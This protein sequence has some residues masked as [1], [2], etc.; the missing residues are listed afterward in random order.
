M[1]REWSLTVFVVAYLAAGGFLASSRAC[2][3]P[4]YRFA[5][6]SRE[7]LPWEY[8]VF[9]LH[10][11]T[12]V[13]DEQTTA[14]NQR[15][16]E[17]M[18]TEPVRTNLYFREI[19]VADAE[20]AKKLPPDALRVWEESPDKSGGL[21]V[22]LAPPCRH[23]PRWA[24]LLAGRLDEAAVAGLIGS[25]AR[26]AMAASLAKGGI[27]MILLE[28]ASPEANDAAADAI[29]QTSADVAASKVRR[30]GG[31]GDLVPP[32]EE[33]QKARPNGGKPVEEDVVSVPV[34]LIR[35]RRDDEREK[36]FVEMLML[37]EDDL[38]SLAE[39]PM[40]FAGYGRGR[41]GEPF[42]GQGI[43]PKNLA[44]ELIFLTGACSCEVK[45]QNPGMDLLTTAD[46]DAAAAAMT[47]R[48]GDEEGSEQSLN[49]GDLVPSLSSSPPPVSAKNDVES[50]PRDAASEPLD[51]DGPTH[52][53]LA[54]P[55]DAASLAAPN[56][57]PNDRWLPAEG[58]VH[59]AESAVAE[60]E[61][62]EF[63]RSMAW[64]IGASAAV[65]V[66]LLVALSAL[67]L[68]SAGR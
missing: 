12:S 15:L 44:S 14:I 55:R 8:R 66:V 36:F 45:D 24:T 23:R 61:R 17:L 60:A 26:R 53:A 50:P 7:W 65:V 48:F 67:Y 42:V 49:I 68:R 19:N 6:Y 46:W 43:S 62:G 10:D 64:T 35:V 30:R 54:P 51:S 40:V 2:D 37:V 16:R 28:G 32:A 29:E 25:P 63:S 20:Q 39:Q 57:A 21:H 52:V 34:D 11:D 3:T 13:A 47:E 31:I 1:N 27:P 56:D 58:N 18:L 41:V 22:V 38:A 9:Y 4:V 33:G 59:P 5:L